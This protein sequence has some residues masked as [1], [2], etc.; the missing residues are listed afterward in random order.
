MIQDLFVQEPSENLGPEL[1]RTCGCCGETKPIS[2]FYKDGTKP[3]GSVRYR[4]D[5]KQCYQTVRRQER[6]AKKGIRSHRK[7]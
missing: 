3:D 7:R 2:E 4:R 6:A 1:E 5:C